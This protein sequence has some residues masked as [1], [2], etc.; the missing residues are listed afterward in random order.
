MAFV[1]HK[2]HCLER[3]LKTVVVGK[4]VIPSGL[5]GIPYRRGGVGFEGTA[6]HVIVGECAVNHTWRYIKVDRKQPPLGSVVKRDTCAVFL[7]VAGLLYAVGIAVV[8][9]RAIVGVCSAAAYSECM[10][11]LEGS[12]LNETEQVFARA[13][14]DC[15]IARR[16]TQSAVVLCCHHVE[17]AVCLVP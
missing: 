1:L 7:A 10:L 3:I 2:S 6:E 17:V 9:G 11:L 12:L 5:V 4:I 13:K 15:D 16:N 14:I 8:D